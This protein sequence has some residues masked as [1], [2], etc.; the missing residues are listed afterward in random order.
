MRNRL[1]HVEARN[2]RDIAGLMDRLAQ[3]IGFRLAS[4]FGERVV[5]RELFHKGLTVLDLDHEPEAA[6]PTSSHQSA[7][8]EI[9]ALLEALGVFE[10]EAG[11]P[12][13]AQE[14]AQEPAPEPARVTAGS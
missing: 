12:E 6:A 8:A 10:E 7:R 4:G 9:N 14:P 5:F 11:A 3:R 13:P 1:S 2:K